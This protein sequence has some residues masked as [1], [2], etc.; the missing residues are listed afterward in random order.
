MGIFD[1]IGLTPLLERTSGRP[2]I[3]VGLIDGPVALDHPDLAGQ[4]IREIRASV[5]TGCADRYSAACAHGTFVAGILAAR[6]RSAAPAICPGCTFLLRP[7][8]P[9]ARSLRG[10]APATTPEELASAIVDTVQA[11]ARVLNLSANVIGFSGNGEGRLAEALD[12]AASRGV[13]PVVAAANQGGYPGSALVTHRWALPVLAS[14]QT[15]RPLLSSSLSATVGRRGIAAPGQH[16]VSLGTD[17]KPLTLT[18]TSAATAFVTGAIGLLWS[19][20]PGARAADVRFA[21]ANVS[22]PRRTGLVP[23]MLNAWSAYQALAAMSARTA[24]NG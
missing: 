4:R 22:S 24:L 3:T 13:I 2:E 12:F 23:P 17:G 8:F 14:D 15:G 5:P 21:I 19:E 7:I 6:R 18:G 10:D 20:L 11:G 16:I 1:V 9:E